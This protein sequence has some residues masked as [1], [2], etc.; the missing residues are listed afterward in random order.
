MSNVIYAKYNR[1][2][3]P[4][5]QTV[6]KILLDGEKKYVVK[7]AL[8]KEAREHVNSLEYKCSRLSGIY[9]SVKP[10]GCYIKDD[11]AFFD[12][13][14]AQTVSD[15]IESKMLSI[16]DI[17]DNVKKY[18]DIIFS[19]KEDSIVPF[20][21][22]ED[23]VSVFGNITELDGVPAV[24]G[25]DVDLIFDNILCSKDGY[26]C[27]DYEWFVD[28]V[29]PIDFI[30][31]RCLFYFYSKNSSYFKNEMEITDF[32]NCFGID[33]KMQEIYK[34]MDESFQQMVHGKNWKNIYTRNYEKNVCDLK[35]IMHTFPNI[36]STI[37][38]QAESIDKLNN[39]IRD[40]ESAMATERIE[41]NEKISDLRMQ[42]SRLQ[43]D[44]MELK[45]QI[46]LFRNLVAEKEWMLVNKKK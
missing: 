32:M 17:V 25:A 5:Y 16:D 4:K 46:D 43:K 30:R 26:I 8:M 36:E 44:N 3:V 21:K 13:C 28:F 22:T 15:V 18:S 27:I 23:F 20:F 31:Y 9:N 24:V 14:E 35:K 33:D 29:I 34:K 38:E 37:I 42:V 10:L 40:R 2:R 11:V 41:V 12:Y 6:T 7:E 19:F 39:Y 45:S 1:T